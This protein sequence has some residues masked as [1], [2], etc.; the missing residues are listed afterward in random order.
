MGHIAEPNLL[1]ITL[2]NNDKELFKVTRDSIVHN[3][4]L[5]ATHLVFDS[6]IEPISKFY[7]KDLQK[8]HFVHIPPIGIYESMNFAIDWIQEKV[9]GD[10]FVLFLNSG[11][12]LNIEFS[13]FHT[14]LQKEDAEFI[15]GKYNVIDPVTN[16][17]LK[18]DPINWQSWNQY[19]SLR[20]IC[21]QAI[22][23]RKSSF[24][25]NGKFNTEFRVGADWDFILRCSRSAKF[26][27]YPFIFSNFQL[28]GYSSNRKK[29]GNKELLQIRRVH[30]PKNFSFR[31]VSE[32]FYIWRHLRILLLE[33]IL[34]R[35]PSALIKVRKIKGW[36][37]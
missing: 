3:Q 30:G 17:R 8:L 21:H 12:S 36:H 14:E 34:E 23:A 6:S 20:P 31:V 10:P 15:Y 22:L 33:H 13:Q 5:S 32:L 18:M 27:Y 35:F 28:G 37:D 26:K 1:I 16:L 2:V 29:L 7:A 11:D 24:E 4:N 19:F 9:V 25:R